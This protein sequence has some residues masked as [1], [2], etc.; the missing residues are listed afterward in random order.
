MSILGCLLAVLP[1]AAE[2]CSA[3]PA[4]ASFQRKGPIIAVEIPWI[5]SR[6]NSVTASSTVST[7]SP[8]QLATGTL[9][10]RPDVYGYVYEALNTAKIA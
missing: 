10:L 7:P 6:V 3:E 5:R 4:K 9:C 1:P 8:Q 2:E